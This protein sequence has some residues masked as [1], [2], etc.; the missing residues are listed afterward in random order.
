MLLTDSVLPQQLLFT[1][2]R[3]RILGKERSFWDAQ[4]PDVGATV[5]PG[6][7]NFFTSAFK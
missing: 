2:R 7:L 3:N 1:I 6:I 5:I 4:R